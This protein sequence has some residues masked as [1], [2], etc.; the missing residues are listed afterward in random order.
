MP[1]AAQL[2][3]A[4]A[5]PPLFQFDGGAGSYLWMQIK[6]ALLTAI[7]LGIAY[8]WAVSMSYRWRCE[9]TLLAGR[10]LRFIGSGGQL[11]GQWIV[12]LILIVITLG[13]YGFWVAPKMQKWA[14][15]NQIY[16]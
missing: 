8:P 4:P 14:I 10:R 9:H 11:F 6:A 2:V 13:I 1:A 15:E 7:T 5:V 16:A 3:T 12:W